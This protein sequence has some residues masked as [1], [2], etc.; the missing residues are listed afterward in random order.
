MSNLLHSTPVDGLL[1]K[2]V[3][4]AAEIKNLDSDMQM[5]VYEN[6]NKFISA[7]DTIRR[8]KDNVA[9][10]ETSMSLLLET[11]TAVRA[12][13]DGV[14]MTLSR[15]REA[16]EQLNGTRSLLRKVQFIFDL[17]KRLRT[18]LAEENY[19]SAVSAY[20]GALPMLTAYGKTSFQKCREEAEEV[21]QIITQRLK[22]LVQ[23]L[24]RTS[25]HYKCLTQEIVLSEDIPLQ[26]RREATFL[27]QQLKQPVEELMEFYLT[28]HWERLLTA[29]RHAALQEGI[30]TPKTPRS[31]L[32]SLNQ[33]F[34]DDFEKSA[35]NFREIFP[36]AEKRLLEAT[37]H[38]FDEYFSSVEQSFGPDSRAPTATELVGALRTLSADVV[39]SHKLVPEANLPDR[40]SQF[41]ER[42]VRRH[43]NTEAVLV[44]A[45]SRAAR[46]PGVSMPSMST[47]L[48]DG[49]LDLPVRHQSSNNR[50]HE[51][52]EAAQAA[53]LDGSLLVIQDLEILLDDEVELLAGW[54]DVYVDLV[55][56]CFQ[57]YCT[58]LQVQFI[59]LCLEN[60]VTLESDRVHQGSPPGLVLFL[61]RLA[62]YMEQMVIPRIT[63]YLDGESQRLGRLVRKSMATPNWLKYK[64]PRGV[65]MIVDLLLQE[66]DLFGAHVAAM[67]DDVQQLLEPGPRRLLSK[68]RAVGDNSAGSSVRT[69]EGERWR[70][71][72]DGRE[73][74]EAEGGSRARTKLL[75]R[76][77]AKLFAQKLELFKKL[78]D[79]Q[80]VLICL[81]ISD[82]CT[83]RLSDSRT[84]IPQASVVSTV[85]KLGLKS[86]QECV[87]LETF[88]KNGYRQIQLDMLY[89]RQPLRDCVD[90]STVVDLLLDEV[91]AAAAERCFDPVPLDKS[92][93]EA[94][95]LDKRTKESSLLPPH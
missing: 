70:D 54:R 20:M 63:E 79:N 30:A 66:V 81:N 35:S 83:L 38:L 71:V 39:S 61:S 69:R 11:V 94:I 75:E 28:E 29:A 18:F 31:L 57:D 93:A 10:M 50:L 9:G 85:V 77:V 87:R 88:G 32:H 36:M 8:M 47:D 13:S 76:D 33:S 17:P 6:Y 49:D 42:A 65:R 44:N 53:V 2:H 1:K 92:F 86:F 46:L 23:L 95:V 89:L 64:E 90:D 34:M 68:S 40:A 5:L 80:F 48:Q 55:Q 22:E 45:R 43:S 41:M 4:M 27:L 15:R 59:K 60:R 74:G 84:V 72:G 37:K 21:V 73:R 24:P 3:E 12:K 56:Q 14:N 58:S 78:E 7:T 91:C 52:L 62:H 25:L 16:I 82:T 51:A 19:S 67:E 26:R